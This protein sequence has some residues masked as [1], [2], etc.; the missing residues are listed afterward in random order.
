M[1][2]W[3]RNY[4]ILRTLSTVSQTTDIHGGTNDRLE[5]NHFVVGVKVDKAMRE[6][7]EVISSQVDKDRNNMRIELAFGG[8]QTAGTIYSVVVLDKRLQLLPGSIV[9]S[10]RS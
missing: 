7:E 5:N 4:R 3:I 2:T 9:R 10:V 6:T 1:V 8:N